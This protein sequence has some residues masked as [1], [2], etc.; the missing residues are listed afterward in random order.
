MA[1]EFLRLRCTPKL[2]ST[3]GQASAIKIIR[4]KANAG[5]AGRNKFP[6]VGAY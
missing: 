1:N 2:P 3:S 5:Y 6:L 4:E